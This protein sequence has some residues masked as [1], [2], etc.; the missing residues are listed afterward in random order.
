MTLVACREYNASSPFFKHR[1]FVTNPAVAIANVTHRYGERVALDALSLSIDAGEIFTLLGPNGSGKTTLFRLLSTLMPIGEGE[2]TMA[3]HSVR[4]EPANVRSQL[5]VVFQSPSVDK[6]L[7][8]LENLTHHARLYG[9]GGSAMRSRVMELL[10]QVGLLARARDY[11]ST[12]S[13]GQ[14]R[15][16]E[17][18]KGLLHRPSIL[19]LDEPSTGLD[20]GARNDLWTYLFKLRQEQS[21]TIV[22]TTHLLEEAD[23]A[24]RIGI[25]HQ[26]KLVALDTPSAL[27]S[28]I[29]GDLVTIRATNATHLA[30][31]LTS[32]FDFTPAIVDGAI[33][34]ELDGGLRAIE[35]LLEQFGDEIESVT[36]GKPTL[37]DVFI[38]RTGHRFF[39]E[40]VIA[41]GIK[42][43]KR[44]H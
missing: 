9:L 11:V 10:D 35:P 12:L 8:V 41:N 3:G 33:R 40:P 36:V 23:R 44:G 43:K 42:K 28:S 4:H 32:K 27:R 19:I 1:R 20:P 39:V 30:E 2:I 7:T 37:E 17:L 5:G 25:L 24:S 29:G 16:V 38:A 26:G 22:V 14:R 15:R 6:Q 18:A 13:G 21:M 34:L 31:R